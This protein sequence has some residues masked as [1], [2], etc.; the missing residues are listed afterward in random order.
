MDHKWHYSLVIYAVWY[1]NYSKISVYRLDCTH[2]QIA[3]YHTV[4]TTFVLKSLRQNWSF[5]NQQSFIVS[6]SLSQKDYADWREEISQTLWRLIYEKLQKWTGCARNWRC[7]ILTLSKLVLSFLF[8]SI[9]GSEDNCMPLL[10][11]AFLIW[12]ERR[13]RLPQFWPELWKVT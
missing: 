12:Y 5:N 4:K 13:Y 8:E 10:W 7:L 11:M 6:M 9:F 1:P 3:L 2:L